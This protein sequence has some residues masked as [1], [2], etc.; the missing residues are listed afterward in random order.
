MPMARLVAEAGNQEQAV[1]VLRQLPLTGI[2]HLEV[3]PRARAIR[4][5]PL[6]VRILLRAPVPSTCRPFNPLPKTLGEAT[7]QIRGH[8]SIMQ[9]R[10]NLYPTTILMDMCI[11]QI[12]VRQE[13]I[14]QTIPE[15]HPEE[16]R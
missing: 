11:G 15:Q 7:L 16:Q 5:Q 1:M 2:L 13:P 9:H 12:A 6:G 8:H 14:L 3:V 4:H 10:D